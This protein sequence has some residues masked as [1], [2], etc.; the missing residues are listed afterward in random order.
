MVTTLEA[1]SQQ[2][3]RLARAL[4]IG[5]AKYVAPELENPREESRVKL[6]TKGNVDKRFLKL[7]DAC[8]LLADGFDA[9]DELIE[10]YALA[11]PLT[12]YDTGC[13]DADRFLEWLSRHTEIDAEQRDLVVCQQSR[14]AI[15]FVALKQRLAHVRFQEMLSNNERLLR[16]LDRNGTIQI[17][18]NP[19]HVWAKFE[20]RALLDEESTVPA[21][22]L[23]YPVENDIRTAVVED[24]ARGLIERVERTPVTMKRLLRDTPQWQRHSLM[25]LIKDLCQLGIVALA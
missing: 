4:S 14:H 23:F 12:A 1:Y 11:V 13:S 17:H 19:I 15:E 10:Q 21:T 8:E 25:E 20:T 3:R 5:D 18:L 24:D 2:I 22:V 7:Q 9:L 16:E 6:F